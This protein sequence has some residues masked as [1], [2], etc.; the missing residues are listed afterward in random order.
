[1]TIIFS[2]EYVSVLLSPTN[3]IKFKKLVSTTIAPK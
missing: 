1:M 2:T 3:N